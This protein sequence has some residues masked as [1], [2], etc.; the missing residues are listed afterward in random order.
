MLLAMLFVF[1]VAGI[2]FAAQQE[3]KSKPEL[4]STILASNLVVISSYVEMTMEDPINPYVVI[5]EQKWTNWVGR[6]PQYFR[7]RM[8]IKIVTP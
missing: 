2:V 3:I 1:I 8:E 6:T 4:E 5:R 7:T